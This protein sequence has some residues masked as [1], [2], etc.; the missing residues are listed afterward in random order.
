MFACNIFNFF[1]KIIT[2]GIGGVYCY[3][4]SLLLAYNHI[5][6]ILKKFHSYFYNRFIALFLSA[7]N[8]TYEYMFLN[9]FI[10]RLSIFK[11][12]IWTWAQGEISMPLLFLTIGAALNKYKIKVNNFIYVILSLFIW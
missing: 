8:S 12:Q 3:I 6:T 2:V 4:I 5:S 1:L 11:T 9:T 7:T 10:Q